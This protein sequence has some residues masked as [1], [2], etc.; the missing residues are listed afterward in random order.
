MPPEAVRFHGGCT[1]SREQWIEARRQAMTL[2]PETLE[3]AR[4]LRQRA[5]IAML[6]NNGSLLK[7]SLPELVPEVCEVF[8]REMHASFEF[9][10]RKPDRLVFDRLLARYAVA[11]DQALLI[12][13]DPLNVQGAQ[14]AGLHALLFQN[15][16]KLREELSGFELLRREETGESRSLRV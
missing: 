16:A 6:T 13:D 12:D 14:C 1:L 5:R 11:R 2:I 15:P 10:A 8:G 9:N 7:E 3:I 4:E